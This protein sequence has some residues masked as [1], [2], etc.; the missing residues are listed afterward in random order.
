MSRRAPQN[1]LHPG[2]T[3]TSICSLSAICLRGKVWLISI[4]EWKSD[5]EDEIPKQMEAAPA[6][7]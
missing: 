1:L 7:T 5:K 4:S 2:D 6:K 3:D